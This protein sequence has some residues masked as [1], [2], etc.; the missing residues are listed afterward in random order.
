MAVTADGEPVKGAQSDRLPLVIGEGGYLPGFE[1]QLVGLEPGASKSF[2]LEFPEDYREAPLRGKQ[3]TFDVTMLD[4]RE[5]RLPE[6]D[7]EFAKSVSNAQTVDGLR[8]EVRTALERQA[9]LEARHG[10]AD[11]IIEFASANATVEIPEVMIAN[12]VEIMRDELRSRLARQRIALDQ[13]LEL[14]KQS[15]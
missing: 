11:R 12:E 15:P 9:V 6:L 4:R 5:K 13:Y 2:D 8:E 7:D 3:A 10:F 14:S 1:D